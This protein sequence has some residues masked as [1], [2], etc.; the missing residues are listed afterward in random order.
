[1]VAG[2][3]APSTVRTRAVAPAGGWASRRQDR[4][5]TASM[6]PVRKISPQ[7]TFLRRPDC[8]WHCSGV[9]CIMPSLGWSE[10][11]CQNGLRQTPHDKPYGCPRPRGHKMLRF[12]GFDRFH[13]STTTR[14]RI[15]NKG[16]VLYPGINV[17]T[18]IAG[19]QGGHPN[20]RTGFP[21]LNA[22]PFAQGRQT[23]F[24]GRVGG[25]VA[26]HAT[27]SGYRRHSHQM[28]MVLGPENFH[29]RFNLTEGGEKVGFGG[30]AVDAGVPAAQG[31][32]FADAGIND[33]P[34]QLAKL[35]PEPV[36]YIDHLLVLVNI[37]RLH[38]DAK[39]RI[40]LL[41]LLAQGFQTPGP[42]GAEGQM[43]A[44]RSEEHTSELQS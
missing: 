26:G 19:I 35:L 1:M 41:Q 30:L 2:L 5:L 44:T 38:A 31:L 12:S 11:A 10:H 27:D 14:L 29:G 33:N 28:A 18:D 40:L 13:H 23:G 25:D 3:I 34:V 36:K 24:S 39:L 32:T 8:S 20:G 7:R 17:G 37:Q 21:E 42:T 43:V 9:A 6:N 22:Q 4:E 16:G 15:H